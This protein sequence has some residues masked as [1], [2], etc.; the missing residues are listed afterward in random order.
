M[1]NLLELYHCITRSQW[2]KY[3]FALLFVFFTY[4]SAWS[5][6]RFYHV[7]NWYP[8][9]V[10]FLKFLF[11][12]GLAWIIIVAFVSKINS[13]EFIYAGILGTSTFWFSIFILPDLENSYLFVLNLLTVLI[14]IVIL[15]LHFRNLYKTSVN[16]S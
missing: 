5:A 9:W 8:D 2:F 3:P 1:K 6:Y 11:Y 12:T 7:I 14:G 13:T 16:K 10:H 15:Y 4:L